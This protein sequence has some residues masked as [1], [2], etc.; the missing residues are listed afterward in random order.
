[1][2]MVTRR[3]YTD[4]SLITNAVN[5]ATGGRIQAGNQTHSVSASANSQSP[6]LTDAILSVLVSWKPGCHGGI[7]FLLNFTIEGRFLSRKLYVSLPHPDQLSS[8]TQF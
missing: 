2:K 4:Y 7:H 5:R 6:T 3:L 1:M 8:L